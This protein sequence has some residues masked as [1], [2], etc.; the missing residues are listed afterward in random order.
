LEQ[1]RTCLGD[2]ARPI[3]I[4]PLIDARTGAQTT[5]TVNMGQ[6][7]ESMVKARHA[8]WRLQPLTR[9]VLDEKPLLLIGTL[10]PTVRDNTEAPPEAFRV[11]LTVIDLRSGRVVAKQQ[12]LS[13]VESV[14]PTPLRFYSDSPT[15]HKDRS[16][17][18]YI[19]SCIATTKIGDPANSE[20]LARLPAAALINEAVIAYGNEQW[21][22][23]NR[24]YAEA[25]SSADPGD[26]RVLNGLY[27]TNWKLGWPDKARANFGQLVSASLELEV[28]PM[29]FLFKTG[30]AEFDNS[31]GMEPQYAMWI[32]VL[33]Q[34]IGKARS[35]IQVQGHTSRTGSASANNT[36]S[37]R[38]AEVMERLLERDNRS[39][40]TRLSVKGF[41]SSR[42]LVGIGTDD[43]RDALDRRV[44][45]RV[46]GCA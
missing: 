43:L 15:W 35:C 13:T 41:G 42:A 6:Q 14:N 26:L 8:Y 27:L 9:R 5:S 21:Q 23:A 16:V 31:T 34:E 38:R 17:Q 28:L 2:E 10:T 40:G 30:S 4:D 36:L 46:V 20:Y 1:A 24:L 19:N 44:E 12:D 45:F 39:L 37:R 7:L 22:E 32:G 3:V 18:G 25:S 33:S 29:K 11:W